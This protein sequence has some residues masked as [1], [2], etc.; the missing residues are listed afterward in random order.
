MPWPA[1]DGTGTWKPAWSLLLPDSELGGRAHSQPT[2]CP[3]V[4]I[5][6][7]SAPGS[8]I[9]PAAGPMAPKCL[10]L[11]LS[12][13]PTSIEQIR[14]RLDLPGSGLIPLHSTRL[15]F[16]HGVVVRAWTLSSTAEFIFC[17]TTHLLCDLGQMSWSL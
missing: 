16:C 15:A 6:G 5:P 14:D 12:T 10:S 4:H 9:N 2:A 8:L 7:P 3:S 1:G 17:F 13:L 11:T